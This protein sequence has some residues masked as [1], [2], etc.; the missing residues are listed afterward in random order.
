MF[1]DDEG[2][3][4]R[5]TLL[6]D[7]TLTAKCDCVSRLSR[8]PKANGLIERSIPFIKLNTISQAYILANQVPSTLL[9]LDDCSVLI[10]I[11]LKASNTKNMLQV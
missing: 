2:E 5:S 7:I 4:I 10:D 6:E 1:Y 11:T 3:D 8:N 9:G